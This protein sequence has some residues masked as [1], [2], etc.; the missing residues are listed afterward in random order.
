M[1]TYIID[2]TEKGKTTRKGMK[3]TLDD[4]PIP[5]RQRNKGKRPQN[6]KKQFNHPRSK[7]RGLSRKEEKRKEQTRSI[8]LCDKTVRE[9]KRG[10][11]QAG[12]IGKKPREKKEYDQ[13]TL[14]T[15]ISRLWHHPKSEG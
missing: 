11:D 7:E 1:P 4:I 5:M 9:E 3:C 13:R 6:V 14:L 15:D 10:E 12:I 8:H 2:Q